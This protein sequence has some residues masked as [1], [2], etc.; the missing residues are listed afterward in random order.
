VHVLGVDP[1]VVGGG[2]SF[3]ANQVLFLLPAPKG[4][5]FDDLFDFPFR[6]VVDDIRGGLEIVR[7][8]F[9][10]FAVRGK[11]GSMEDIMDLPCFRE[12]EAVCN[13]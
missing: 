9:S 5:G 6:S 4:T 13:V 10:R 11:K 1:G 8:M 7:A 3:P 2:I 12:V